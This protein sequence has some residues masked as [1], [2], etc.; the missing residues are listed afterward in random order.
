MLRFVLRGTTLHPLT[1]QL[2]ASERIVF[3]IFLVLWHFAMA[4]RRTGV[5]S[6]T[7]AS[8]F[9]GAECVGVASAG[10]L[11]AEM[12]EMAVNKLI[13]QAKE[14]ALVASVDQATM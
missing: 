4:D 8:A 9:S 3:S 13:H 11:P 2:L 6:A 1:A 14:G 5:T 7:M 10:M 12:F